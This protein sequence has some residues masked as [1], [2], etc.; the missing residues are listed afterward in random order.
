MQFAA[1]WSRDH[2]KIDVT[3]TVSKADPEYSI[4]TGLTATYGDLLSSVQLPDGW[5]WEG[6]GTVGNVGTQ[7]HTAAFTP[8]DTENYNVITGIDVTVTV[9]PVPV[10]SITDV[11][12][13]ATISV[14]LTLTGIV[15]PSNATYQDIVWTVVNKGTTDAEIYNDNSFFAT[16]SG[17]AVIMATITDGSAIGLNYTQHFYITVGTTG[18]GEILSKSI[19]IFP[20]PVKEELKIESEN[21]KINSVE[22]CD[23]AGK[24]LMSQMFRETTIN[25]SLLPHGVYI[26][27]IYTEK[28]I[29]TQ[30]IVKN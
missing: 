24:T 21:L 1:Q 30:K 20:N 2:F 6:T 9:Q 12:S 13:S 28:G 18:I 27:K 7:T 29:V 15:V 25:V 8:T 4:P 3:I 19:S 16:T 14:P 5:A 17:I 26:V 23:I 22:I 11:P 10:D